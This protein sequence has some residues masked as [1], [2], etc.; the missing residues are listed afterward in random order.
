MAKRRQKRV[1]IIIDPGLPFGRQVMEGAFRY[2]QQHKAWQF[3]EENSMPY[4]AHGEVSRWRG[5]GVIGAGGVEWMRSCRRRGIP[6]VNVGSMIELPIPSVVVDNVAIGAM[7]AEYLLSKRLRHFAIVYRADTDRWESRIEGFCDAIRRSGFKVDRIAVRPRNPRRPLSGSDV[8]GVLNRIK[9]LSKPVGLFATHDGLAREVINCCVENDIHVP[10]E[11]AV[12]GEGDQSFICELVLPR[13]TSVDSGVERVG[14]Q[15]AAM[16]HRLMSG[17]K[18]SKTPI[19]VPPVRVVER[20]STDIRDIGSPMVAKTVQ[21][22]R[23]HIDEPLQVGDILEELLIN[24]RRLE[25]LFR[26]ELDRTVYEEIR[27]AK[28]RRACDLLVETDMQVGQVC[29]ACGFSGR[30]RFNAAFRLETGTTPSEF[31]RTRKVW[32][33]AGRAD[34]PDRRR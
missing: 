13:L 27:R 24:R 33:D 22:I 7:A 19:L 1:A 6:F 2:S 15:A 16:L 12:I 18:P 25:R 8:L 17:G 30:V 4:L 34:D 10:E 9:K 29:R 3:H 28:I 14:Y 21:Y 20:E 5:D 26:R 11:V 32:S 23:D 31:R